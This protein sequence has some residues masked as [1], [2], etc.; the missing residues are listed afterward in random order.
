M[1]WV[2]RHG[3]LTT[4]DG[5]CLDMVLMSLARKGIWQHTHNTR[6]A[7]INLL[8][9]C[10]CQRLQCSNNN[11]NNMCI[12]KEL[13]RPRHCREERGSHFLQLIL[14]DSAVRWSFIG[15]LS[16]LVYWLYWWDWNMREIYPSTV[17]ARCRTTDIIRSFWVSCF[18]LILWSRISHDDNTGTEWY[19]YVP[20]R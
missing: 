14:P 7:S 20:Y 10:P 2:S 19:Q 15:Q 8:S 4:N 9:T 1:F 18:I 17:C 12:A 16:V 11:N 5:E 6:T 13:S 3:G